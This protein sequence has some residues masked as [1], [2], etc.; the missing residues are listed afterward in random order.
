M[1]SGRNQPTTICASEAVKF[2]APSPTLR[3]MAARCILF[4]PSSQLGK[5][6]AIPIPCDAK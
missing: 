2:S 5:L 6:I 1:I 3:V 4:N